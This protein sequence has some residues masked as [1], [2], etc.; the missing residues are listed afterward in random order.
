MNKRRNCHAGS[1]Y[2][3]YVLTGCSCLAVRSSRIA[4]LRRW[5]GQ[6]LHFWLGTGLLKFGSWSWVARGLVR[7]AKVSI[8]WSES[9]TRL[10][11]DSIWYLHGAVCLFLR[12]SFAVDGCAPLIIAGGSVSVKPHWTSKPFGRWRKPSPLKLQHPMIR[13]CLNLIGPCGF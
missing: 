12:E 1:P 6:S 9:G 7:I 10:S 2:A 11:W 5:H 4:L 3:N 8:R 13:P